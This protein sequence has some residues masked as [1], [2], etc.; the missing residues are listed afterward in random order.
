MARRK[1][2]TRLKPLVEFFH[3]VGRARLPIDA[4]GVQALDLHVLQHHLQNHGYRVLVVD[5]VTHSHPEVL[6]RRL[7]VTLAIQTDRFSKLC[8]NL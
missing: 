2:L 3:S 4:L 7:L 6:T 8:I 1:A 5:Q